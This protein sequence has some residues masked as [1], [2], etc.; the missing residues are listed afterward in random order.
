MSSH[1]S[2]TAAADERKARLAKL[3]SLKRKAPS[4]EPEESSETHARTPSPPPSPS[5]EI[6]LTHLSGRNY[7]PL[8]KGPK[9][10][11]EAPPTLFSSKPTLE[12][13]AEAVAEEVRRKAKEE[14]E[15]EKGVDLFTLQP[16]KPNWDLKR[17]LERKMEMLGAR[18]DNAVAR[19]V[20]MRI[21][22]AQKTG[23]GEMGMDGA[24]LVEGVKL[25]QR[26]NEDAEMI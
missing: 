4:Q 14:E 16:K 12:E 15:D 2:L 17:D 24:V 19:L 13:Q 5:T 21:E 1:R 26:E 6:A 20:R 25:R 23:G 11:F 7:D 10:G 9:L 3:K 8:S 18:T 22:S